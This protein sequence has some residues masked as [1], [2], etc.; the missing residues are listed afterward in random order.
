VRHTTS[1]KRTFLLDE[2]YGIQV[3]V[4]ASFTALK[5]SFVVVYHPQG[6]ECTFTKFSNSIYSSLCVNALK[7]KHDARMRLLH[8]IVRTILL[9]THFQANFDFRDKFLDLFSSY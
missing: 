2:E 1:V 5:I 6:E 9:I 4:F 3:H 8:N 7:A